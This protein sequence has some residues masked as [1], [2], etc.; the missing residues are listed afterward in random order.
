MKKNFTLWITLALNFAFIS[1][2]NANLLSNGDLQ[3]GKLGWNLEARNGSK[4]ELKL[5]KK[6]GK[7]QLQVKVLKT[8]SNPWDVQ[9]MY[10]SGLKLEEGASYQFS[11]VISAENTG[12]DIS[13]FPGEHGGSYAAL[14]KK[15]TLRPGKTPRKVTHTFTINRQ[16]KKIRMA[17]SNLGQQNAVFYISD[18]NL[19][20]EKGDA[21]ALRARKEAAK[22][23]KQQK[24]EV[25]VDMFPRQEI[26]GW[27]TMVIGT[28]DYKTTSPH[29]E[30]KK[31]VETF[32]NMGQTFVRADLRTDTTW[33]EKGNMKAWQDLPAMLR[34]AQKYG[35]KDYIITV[36]SPPK[37]LKTHGCD[38]GFIDKNK[39]K[40]REKD[41][42]YTQLP[43]DKEDEFI[44]WYIGGIKALQKQGFPLPL[45]LS[46]QNEPNEVVWYEGCF[47]EPDQWVRMVKKMRKALDAAGFQSI[48]IIG[49]E[50]NYGPVTK[51]EH[52]K[53]LPGYLGDSGF[54]TLDKDPELRQAL[55]AYAFH[56]YNMSNMQGIAEGMARFPK[57]SW[58]TENSDP[59]GHNAMS[60]ALYQTS[61]L[62]ADMIGIPNNYWTF[63]STMATG[64]AAPKKNSLLIGRDDGSLY[65]SKV[66]HSLKRIWTSVRPG[67][68]VHRVNTN[69][70]K[71]RNSIAGQDG[72]VN[73]EL[74]AFRS[75]DKKQTFVVLVNQEKRADNDEL[76][77]RGLTGKTAEIYLLDAKNNPEK[78]IKTI[79]VKGGTIP[80]K[81]PPFSVT[82][83]WSK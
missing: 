32:Y 21:A 75:P 13:V 40:K 67:W 28:H 10:Y 77:L 34:T 38:K 82:Y 17:I 1:I 20:E 65:K 80:I 19:A 74:G 46:I 45:N 4:A 54:P 68:T 59:G 12:R 8:G 31:A 41:E 83:V 64:S 16:A 24:Y 47:Y 72:W 69:H 44:Q 56:S 58:M 60:L 14:A 71:L 7:P 11:M 76:V 81:L 29:L 25:L 33:D 51:I 39:N 61:H 63:W 50:S 79:P 52:P 62:L 3:Q 22:K 78:P 6:D 70:P 53:K 15:F 36:W 27:G 49:P 23:A 48:Q 43:P 42:P 37:R 5:I 35:L 2:A 66:F 26:K 73:F 9:L 18:V 57:D 30:H 55:G